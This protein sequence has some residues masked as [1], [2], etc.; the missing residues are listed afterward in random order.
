M[1]LHL[2]LIL[3]SFFSFSFP[4]IYIIQSYETVFVQVFFN[5]KEIEPNQ[6]F[7]YENLT[8][9]MNDI[10]KIDENITILLK[11]DIIIND[12]L[13]IYVNCSIGSADVP[14]KYR[15]ILR[16]KAQ[17]QIMN[18][19]N[20]NLNFLIIRNSPKFSLIQILIINSLL[21]AKFEVIF[22]NIHI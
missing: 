12:Y 1:S 17:V 13:L 20:F 21:L 4:K 14:T 9:F 15:M 2:I 7:E 3:F 22:E 16:E 10:Q 6:T 19:N 18:F 8:S 5:E 11:T